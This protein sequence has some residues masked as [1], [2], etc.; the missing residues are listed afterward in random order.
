MTTAGTNNVC[1]AAAAKVTGSLDL[2]GSGT[3]GYCGVGSGVHTP[4]IKTTRGSFTFTPSFPGMTMYKDAVG[5]VDYKTGAAFDS[6]SV[7]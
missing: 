6:D 7:C 1:G 5:V 3:M 2:S 4:N